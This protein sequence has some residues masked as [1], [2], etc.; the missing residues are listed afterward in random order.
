MNHEYTLW[1]IARDRQA[2]M[3]AQADAERE[4]R[5]AGLSEPVIRPGALIVALA[6]I[7]VAAL[8]A[9][10]SAAAGFGG[11]GGAGPVPLM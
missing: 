9:A 6:A 11:G 1:Q 2:E 3:R 4:L 5:E 7:T 10:E 8:L